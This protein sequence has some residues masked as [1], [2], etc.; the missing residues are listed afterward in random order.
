MVADKFIR[1]KWCTDEW[2]WTKWYEQNGTDK[3]LRI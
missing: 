3:I 2:Y 1:T